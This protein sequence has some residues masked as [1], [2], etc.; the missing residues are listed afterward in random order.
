ME[1]K[2]IVLGA[3]TNAKRYS[4]IATNKLM[5]H[6]IPT[7]PMGIKKGEINGL[8]IVN[9]KP[10]YK[11]IHTVTL[12]IGPQRQAEYYNYIVS[13]KPKR[14]I[15]NPGTENPEFEELL[16]KNGIEPIEH[17]TLI[18]LNDGVF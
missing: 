5:K 7:I 13:L 4:Y 1:K 12:Y 15:F 2:T 11:D 9:D 8:E 10:E 18:M 16:I 6:S 17:C 3:S 14:V